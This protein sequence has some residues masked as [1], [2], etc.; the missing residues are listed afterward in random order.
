MEM[1]HRFVLKPMTASATKMAV[2]PAS[3]PIVERTVA[4][5]LPHQFS[6]ELEVVGSGLW[7][8]LRKLLG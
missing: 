4:V 2:T 3:C 5:V 7:P 1:S 8:L 6:E